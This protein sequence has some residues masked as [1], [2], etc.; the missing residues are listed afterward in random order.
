MLFVLYDVYIKLFFENVN[1][2][3]GC[4]TICYV[5]VYGTVIVTGRGY[6]VNVIIRI[7]F[8]CI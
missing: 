7:R 8:K 1:P 4:H 5:C 2:F 6:R 3:L